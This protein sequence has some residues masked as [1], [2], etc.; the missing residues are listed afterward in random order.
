MDLGWGAEQITE[1]RTVPVNFKHRTKKRLV[2]ILNVPP[3]YKPDFIP[4]NKRFGNDIAGFSCAYTY[5][6]NQIIL[7]S[8]IYFNFLMLEP[9]DFKKYN[10]VIAEHTKSI[11]Q[12]VSLIKL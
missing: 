12:A 1:S 6:N 2:T 5:K 9:A 11:K 10:Q 8:D 4:E 3:G 7:I